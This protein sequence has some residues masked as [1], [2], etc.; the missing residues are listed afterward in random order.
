MTS[1]YIVTAVALV[2]SYFLNPQKT[3]MGLKKGWKKFSKTLPTY[4][5]LLMIISLVLLFTEE[6]IIKY[7]S[8]DNLL[9]GLISSLLLGSVTMMPGFI[10]YPL[11]KILV[12]KGVPY[13]VVAGFVTSLMLVGIVTYPL[14]SKYF[15]TKATILRNIMSFVVA[16]LISLLMGIFYGEVFI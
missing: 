5:K 15:G 11:A 2:I 7:L 14:E 12:E 6:T 8:Q 16:G 10:A 4:L 13:M 1:L 3:K 9:L